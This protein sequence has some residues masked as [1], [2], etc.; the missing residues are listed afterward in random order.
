MR[1]PK[2]LWL[3][4]YHLL[5]YKEVHSH[6]VSVSKELYHFGTTFCNWRGYY[7]YWIPSSLRPYKAGFPDPDSH[8]LYCKYFQ[9]TLIWSTTS[10]LYLFYVFNTYTNAS[11]MP[12][13]VN[14]DLIARHW[15]LSYSQL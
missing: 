4:I 3:A 14:K 12:I 5:G 8:L 15:S 2:D 13:L 10:N 6:C 11:N 7:P 1:L 9:I